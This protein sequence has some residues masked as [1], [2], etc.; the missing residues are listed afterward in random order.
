MRCGPVPRAVPPLASWKSALSPDQFAAEILADW[1]TDQARETLERLRRYESLLRKWQARINLVGPKT[2]SDIWG[3][4]F[5]DSAQLFPLLPPEARILID[6]GSG[7][8]FPGL[9]LAILGAGA[10]RPFV[11]HL[12]ESD[13]RKAAFLIEVARETGLA[14]AVHVHAARAETLAG[15]IPPANV[16]TAR[17]LAPVDRLVPLAMPLLAPGGVLMLLKGAKVED[18]LTEARRTWK[19]TSQRLRSRSDPSGEVLLLR[20]IHRE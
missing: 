18:E 13:A 15:K 1:P 5:L 14:Q 3:R 8:G 16:I 2:V 19:M 6:L 10:H 12:V 11:T 4:H 17:A 9:V 20:D 7:A